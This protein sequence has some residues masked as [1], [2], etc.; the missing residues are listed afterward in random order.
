MGADYN[1]V[2]E[3]IFLFALTWTL[4]GAVNEEGRKKLSSC[5]LE[6]DPFVPSMHTVYDYYVDVTKNDFIGWDTKLPS[7]RFMKGMTFHEMIVP[8]VDTLRNSY[9]VDM[10]VSTKKN[11]MVTLPLKFYGHVLYI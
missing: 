10:L 7:F 2:A 3:K 11:V 5:L 1:S 6:I 9:I 4:G 8:T